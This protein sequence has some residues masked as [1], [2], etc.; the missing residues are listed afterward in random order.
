M[1][2]AIYA[3]TSRTGAVRACRSSARRRPANVAVS[4]RSTSRHRR[5]PRGRPR[6]DA[7]QADARRRRAGICAH[8][9]SRP[10]RACT[11]PVGR[12]A[13]PRRAQAERCS[14][15]TRST[16][17]AVY[18][19][20]GDVDEPVTPR[21]ARRRGRRAGRH[22]GARARG[23]DRGEQPVRGADRALQLPARAATASTSRSARTSSEPCAGS[24]RPRAARTD[25]R[26]RP[27]SRRRRSRPRSRRARTGARRARRQQ[28]AARTGAAALRLPPSHAAAHALDAGQRGDGRDAPT[29]VHGGRQMRGPRRPWSRRRRTSRG[30]RG[31]WY[32]CSR[33]ALSPR[34]ADRR[35][36]APRRPRPA[37]Q[38]PRPG[39]R[40]HPAGR[41]PTAAA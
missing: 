11:S 24:R 20:D 37:P 38:A 35:R 5:R 27:R 9:P 31:R 3:R 12:A 13:A 2:A 36:A 16:T 17:W 21:S 7:A 22:D 41:R 14:R 40:R 1:R 23:D 30:P 34:A 32:G 19:G 28:A 39:R 10:K 33:R 15:S 18:L 4:T 25:R 26:G 8:T 6:D 29:V